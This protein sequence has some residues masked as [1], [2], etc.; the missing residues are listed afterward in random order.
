MKTK[1]LSLVLALLMLSSL[2]ACNFG[3]PELP[4]DSPDDI[5]TEEVT[6][7]LTEEV[8]EKI[9]EEIT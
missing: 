5:P 2:T 4:T 1:L 7:R 9:T 3:F 6:E 8:T